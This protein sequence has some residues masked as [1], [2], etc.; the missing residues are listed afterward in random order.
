[1]VPSLPHNR[2]RSN[3]P[4]HPTRPQCHIRRI[5]LSTRGP[6]PC[7]PAPA[8]IQLS[9]MHL[10]NLNCHQKRR[11]YDP[12]KRNETVELVREYLACIDELTTICL[13]LARKIELF[14]GLKRDCRKFERDD[15]MARREPDDPEGISAEARATWAIMMVKGQHDACKKLLADLQL[16]MNAVSAPPQESTIHPN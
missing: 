8:S 3:P 12:W 10:T 11:R 5:R 2:S 14:E 15:I 4:Q 6:G 9:K 1:M 13:I 16:S 7:R